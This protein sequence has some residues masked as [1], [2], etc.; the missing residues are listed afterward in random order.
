MKLTIELPDGTALAFLNVAYMNQN[1]IMMLG[2]VS[3]DSSDLKN[4]HVNVTERL[5]T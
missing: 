2:S 4:G 1:H 5:E 3:I